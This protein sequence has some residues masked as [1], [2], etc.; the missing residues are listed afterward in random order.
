QSGDGVAEAQWQVLWQVARLTGDGDAARVGGE[1]P[2]D[3]APQRGL[4][5]AVVADQG[6]S[7]VGD[8][9][10]E[11]VDDAVAV[12]PGEDEAVVGDERG[13]ARVPLGFDVDGIECETSRR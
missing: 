5:V 2:A 11:A 3:E 7:A 4:S 8:D 9:G 6:G 12:G 13:H 1:Q 10:V